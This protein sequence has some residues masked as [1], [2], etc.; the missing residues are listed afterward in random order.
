MGFDRLIGNERNKEVLQ[1][2]LARQQLGGTFLFA[3]PAGVGKRQFAMELAKAANCLAI[4][5]GATEPCDQCS[6]C[7]RIDE[8]TYGDLLTLTP[9]GPSIRIAQTRAMNDEVHYRPREGR[10]RFFLIDDADRL[11][12]E[13]ANSLL[14]TLEE[15]PPTSTII[16]LTARPDSLL[17]TIRSRARRLTF[18]PLAIDELERYLAAH[19]PR[20]AA[21]TA[22]L[23]RLARGRLGAALS[24]DLSLYRQERRTLVEL[25]ELLVEGERRFRL[26]KA[27]EFLGKKEREEFE[28][29]L[30]L[31]DGLL[32]DLLLV[33]GGA[34]QA[35]VVN[36]D[37]AERLED[38][39]SRL[40]VARLILWI[41]RFDQLRRQLRVNINRQIATEAVLFSLALPPSDPSSRFPARP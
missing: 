19:Y 8:G 6:T 11:R 26:L 30:D 15:P 29:S 27:A 9:D 17:R 1:R 13:A 22:L 21:E 14:K 4:S 16:L 37:I 3:G 2:L 23:A 38:L 12:E 36:L 28:H 31:L 24:I 18:S 41:D 35:A 25:L 39:A 5:P 10:Q 32:R 34:G 40:P 33:A 7:R 20:P